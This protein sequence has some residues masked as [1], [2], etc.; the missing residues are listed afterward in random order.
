MPVYRGSIPQELLDKGMNS[1]FKPGLEK[2]KPRNTF[3]KLI[4]SGVIE[5]LSMMQIVTQISDLTPD[6]DSAPLNLDP[7]PSM[8]H[9]FDKHNL[10]AFSLEEV[11]NTYD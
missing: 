9:H 11:F 10:E 6:E 4:S 8:L 7:I 5:P 2:E 3:K 1:S